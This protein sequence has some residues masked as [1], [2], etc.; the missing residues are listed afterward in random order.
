MRQV[1]ALENGLNESSK[2]TCLVLPMPGQAADGRSGCQSQG[3]LQVLVR[4]RVLLFGGRRGQGRVSGRSTRWL[5]VES[6]VLSEETWWH[7]AGSR[8][9]SVKAE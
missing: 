2:V 1:I 4:V 9:F 6:R 7:P 3:R 5:R 8:A